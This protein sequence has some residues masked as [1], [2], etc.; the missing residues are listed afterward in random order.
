M[1]ARSTFLPRLSLGLPLLMFCALTMG[2]Q[3]KVL[4]FKSA[5]KTQIKG[6]DHLVVLSNLPRGRTARL[7]VANADPAGPYA[8]VP[9]QAQLIQGLK[10]GD[11]IQA[12][13]D[14][15][16][17]VN[18]IS[19]IARYTPKPGELMPNGYIFV[20]AEQKDKSDDLNIV[21]NK[22]G[23]ITNATV[24]AEKD[25]NG[26]VRHD[27]FIQTTLDSLHQGD[28]VWADL[29][30]E[31]SPT[32]IAMLPYTDPAA[33]KL[34]KIDTTDLNGQRVATVQIDAG[35]TAI[36]AIIPGKLVKG[37]WVVNSRLIAAAHRC[38]PGAPILYRVQSDGSGTWLR[39]I[40]P[41]AQPNQPV[42]RQGNQDNGSNVDANGVPKG[43]T[44]GGAG[45]VPG[46]G[47]GIG[48]GGF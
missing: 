28:S 24:A 20:K 9:D 27:A 13:W 38:K 32:V 45:L 14:T 23:E 5:L 40:Q 48:I 11:L 17:T 25:E 18:T 1:S 46:V 15:A 19:A 10:P 34:V 41:Q 31:A 39:D 37:K 8:P 36:S 22:L 21:L 12:S 2:D 3:D 26:D 4:Q 47:G 43:R 33:G 7:V 6:K 42:A 35:G 16:G 29:T 44:I 30:T